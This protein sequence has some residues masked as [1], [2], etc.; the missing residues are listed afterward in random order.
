MVLGNAQVHLGIA[1]HGESF[2]C[3]YLMVIVANADILKREF[4][5]VHAV[6]AS[7]AASTPFLNHEGVMSL[8]LLT[9]STVLILW[10]TPCVSP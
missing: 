3:S 2:L 6:G 10:P 8:A 4:L 1:N 7:K 9:C 5:L